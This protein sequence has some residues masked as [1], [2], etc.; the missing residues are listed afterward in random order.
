[1]RAFA[2][3]TAFVA[4]LA[5]MAL[6]GQAGVITTGDVVPLVNTS[7]DVVSNGLT[8][9]NTATGSLQING[10]STLTDTGSVATLGA[11]AGSNGT[12]IISGAGSALTINNNG[13]N[14]SGL[15]IGRA[16]TGLLRIT[17]G[18]SLALNAGSIMGLRLDLGGSVN[19]VPQANFCPTTSCPGGSGTLIIDG[20]GSTVTMSGFDTGF[21]VGRNGGTGTAVIENGAI[22][23]A[24]SGPT[25]GRNG[26]TGTLTVTGAGSQ[27]IISGTAPDE[28]GISIGRNKGP[29][30][31]AR[32]TGVINILNGGRITV[33]PPADQVGAGIGIGQDGAGT[34]TLNVIGKGSLLSMSGGAFGIQIGTARGGV[35]TVNVLNGGTIAIKPAELLPGV[36]HIIVGAPSDGLG[37]TSGTLNI[38]GEG[39]LVSITGDRPVFPPGLVVGPS[40]FV[41][42][43]GDGTVRISDGG[44]L[45]LDDSGTTGQ[46][47][48]Q[49]GGNLDQIQVGNLVKDA[50]PSPGTVTVTGNGSKIINNFSH[51]SIDVGV[52]ANGSGSL[53]VTHGGSVSTERLDMGKFV[54]AVGTLTVSGRGSLLSLSGD[55]GAGVGAQLVVGRAG[56]G[57]ATISDRASVSIGSTASLGGIMIGGTSTEAGGN[58]TM[59]VTGRSRVA[60]TGTNNR[61]VVGA[62][63]TGALTVS[64]ASV[65]TVARG[66]GSTGETF[67]GLAPTAVGTITIKDHSTLNAGG[68]LGIGSDGV[69]NTGT[70]SVILRGASTVNATNVVIGQKGLLGGNGTVTGNVT[71]NGG[72]LDVGSAQHPLRISG[73]FTQ[74]GGSIELEVTPDGHGGFLTDTLTLGPGKILTLPGG[75]DFRSLGLVAAR[76][77]FLLKTPERIGQILQQSGRDPASTDEANTS[78]AGS[79]SVDNAA[80]PAGPLQLPV[81]SGSQLTAQNARVS[82]SGPLGNM[83]KLSGALSHAVAFDS[84]GRDFPVN[85]AGAVVP[86]STVGLGPGSFASL[87]AGAATVRRFTELDGG[88]YLVSAFTGAQGAPDWLSEGWKSPALITDPTSQLK[89]QWSFGLSLG[90]TY[91]G[92][93]QGAGAALSF[94]DARWGGRTAFSGNDGEVAASLLALS[95]NAS[96]TT[97]GFDLAKGSR[98]SVAV[99]TATDDSL[100]GLGGSSYSR[101]VA[102]GYTFEPAH[103]A[104]WK[105]S[106]TGSLLNERN[107]LL[108]APASGALSLGNNRSVALGLGSNFDLGGGL[109]LGFDALYAT[110]KSSDAAASLIAGTTRMASF[111]FGMALSKEDLFADHDLAGLTIKKPL[112]VYGGAAQV[113]LATGVD[114]DGNPVVA[115]QRV[116]L[117]PT[118]S[119]TVYGVNYNRA[120]A[121]GISA[122]LAVTARTDA[123]NVAGAK[124]LGAML[125]FRLDF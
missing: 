85:L 77:P 81:A 106:M 7:G 50:P 18:G 54:G 82:T 44:I 56:S 19:T 93:G 119:E 31:Q 23:Y 111:G 125:R 43:G 102:L 52:A 115:R 14:Q 66:N 15:I 83:S 99:T 64:G 116:S 108:G 46:G 38:S 60:I 72:I 45:R 92:A 24:A 84:F 80:Q 75:A 40:V 57:T 68:L 48:V 16:G 10:G 36:T 110:T 22:M 101:G 5:A 1:M 89:D 32:P 103:S 88:G 21:D 34:G 42:R 35:G 87:Q 13:I 17:N 90:G 109:Q 30:S 29:G 91:L 12:A 3:N 95:S 124:D 113:D 9:G 123:D 114:G 26:S 100:T 27:L 49:I 59:A 73:N 105:M 117:V 67:V 97:G 112:R 79:S 2:A 65:V 69:N 33:N 118:G 96:Y 71:N 121:A 8:I 41:G 70:G 63:G 39:S 25:V 122:G 4:A 37:G 76:W 62:N 78:G 53:A 94:S 98:F 55:D 11:T 74:T 28:V 47:G 51:G 120:L 58:G 61:L 6:P 107:M 86:K 20:A 104:A